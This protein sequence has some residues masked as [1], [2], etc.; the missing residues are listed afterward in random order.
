MVRFIDAVF[1]DE[2]ADGGSA[3]KVDELLDHF[4]SSFDE[5]FIGA[6]FVFEEQAV[7]VVPG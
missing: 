7:G 3:F 1:S 2:L 4:E 5:E 6:E